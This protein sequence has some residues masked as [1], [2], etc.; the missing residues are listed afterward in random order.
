MNTFMIYRDRNGK[1]TTGNEGQDR[2]L[3]LLYGTMAGRMLLKPLTN[4]MISKF[5]G[6]LLN[7]GLSACA[8]KGFVRKHGICL[9]DYKRAVFSS[10]NDFFC[11]EILPEKRP[12]D[13]RE[14]VLISPCDA[15]LSVYPVLP[16]GRVTIKHTSYTLAEL[17]KNPRLAKKYEGGVL[18]VFRLT[19][20]DYHHYCY[21]DAGET[22]GTVR[23]PGVLHTV[24][25]IA[26]D[27]LPIYK[28]NTREYSLLKSRNFGTVLMMEV[29]ALMVGRI[30]NHPGR[31]VVRRGEEKGHFEFG[32]STVI[33]CMQKGRVRPDDDIIKNSLEGIE[34]IVRMGEKIGRS[35]SAASRSV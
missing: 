26:N 28:E 16:D 6:W 23:I 1:E 17:V 11:R 15:K 8:I 9:A 24:N 31:T 34:T 13:Y 4:P 25:P 12:I 7:T 21:I 19:V 29:G 10:Y 30:V 3:R 33:L 2:V 35:R 27:V 22:T 32:G 18:L 5:G 14:E 20:D